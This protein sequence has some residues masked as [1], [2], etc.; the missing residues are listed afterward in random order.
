MFFFD[1][2]VVAT[3]VLQRISFLLIKKPYV[4]YRANYITITI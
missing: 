1:M 3:D 4:D 2:F